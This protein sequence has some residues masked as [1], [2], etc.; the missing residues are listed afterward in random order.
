MQNRAQDS[1]N[2]LQNPP[3]GGIPPAPHFWS[4]L[5]APVGFSRISATTRPRATGRD[6]G[7]SHGFSEDVTHRTMARSSKCRLEGHPEPGKPGSNPGR[8]PIFA[9]V[10]QLEEPWFCNPE[11]AGS[12]PAGGS[13]PCSVT[14]STRGLQPLS[15]SSN[16]GRVTICGVSQLVERAAVT[17]EVAGSSPAPAA[18][19]TRLAAQPAGA[20]IAETRKKVHS[21]G[22]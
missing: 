3:H 15:S 13:R 10:A 7:V 18:I 2:D 5:P 8:A 17:R 22:I 16:L 20:S 12:N 11:A 1:R 6:S 4:I 14:V 21:Y 9:P 19:Y